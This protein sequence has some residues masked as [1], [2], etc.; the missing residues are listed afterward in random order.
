MKARRAGSRLAAAPAAPREAATGW[1]A[2]LLVLIALLAWARIFTVWFAQDDFRWLERAAGGLAWAPRVLSMSLY[3]RAMRAVFGL[4]PWPYHAAQLALH[5]VTGLLLWSLLGRRV[6]RWTAAVGVACF[7][8]APALFDSLHWISDVADSLA[9]ALLL[10]AAWLLAEPTRERRAWLALLAYALALASKEIA[11]GAA[12][13]LALL[14]ARAGGRAAWL[15]AALC[16]ALALLAA[17]PAAGA[18]QTGTGEPYALRPLAAL[19]N[20]P[21]FLVGAVLGGSAWAAASDLTWSR[22]GWVQIAGWLVLGAWLAALLL[23]RSRAAWL[24][25]LWFMGLIA[26][27]VMLERH[28]YLYYLACA[29]PGLVLSLAC[30]APAGPRAARWVIGT[31]LALLALQLAA[32]QARHGSRLSIAPLPTDFVLRRAVIARNAIRDLRAAEDRLRPKVVLLGQQPVAASAEGTP[33]TGPAE[34]HRDPWLDDNV[35]AALSEGEAVRLMFPQVRQA[36]FQPWLEDGDTASAVA[37]YRYDGHLTLS[38]YASFSGVPDV[39]VPATRAE[40]ERR[41]QVFLS[42]RLF[43]EARRELEAALTLAPRD[44]TLLINLG[45]LQA[46]LG[47]SL[48]AV[49]SLERAVEASPGDVEALYDLGLLQWRLGRERAARATFDRLERAAPGTDLARSVRDLLRGRAR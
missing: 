12:P 48:A 30:L 32:I 5:L 28:F 47:D 41:A 4:Q 18:W 25:F 37:A 11:V 38:D 22:Q 40:H 10:L 7:L 2:A 29:L 33:A 17:V 36:A 20:L 44:P 13:A 23:R 8:T 46:N 35:R 15:R 6:P 19:G 34:Y 14:A 43:L 16:M 26:P 1:T 42:K 9:A 45:V 27:V 39:N 24:G 3:F 49:A 21:A 31:G